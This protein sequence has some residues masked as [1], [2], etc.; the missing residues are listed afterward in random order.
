MR[1]LLAAQTE[2]EFFIRMCALL[3]HYHLKDIKSLTELVTLSTSPRLALELTLSLLLPHAHGQAIG[4]SYDNVWT[5]T[6]YADGTLS[7]RFA[8]FDKA[9]DQGLSTPTYSQLEGLEVIQ[10]RLRETSGE[11]LP[12]DF[13]PASV[14]S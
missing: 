14:V 8:H 1:D 3:K 9:G 7:W 13:L 4:W 2:T 6:L 10:Q 5:F 12:H 11:M